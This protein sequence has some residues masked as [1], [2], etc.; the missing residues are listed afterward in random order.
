MIQYTFTQTVKILSGAEC[1]S[2]IGQLLEENGYKK[3]MLVYDK[4]LESTG[5]PNRIM[6][7]LD[8]K[9]MRYICYTEVL[10]DPPAEIVEQGAK[11]CAE[12]ACD[13]LLAV[14]GGSAIDTAK[15]INILR[16]N[17]GKILDYAA[18]PEYNVCSGLFC[19]P[20]TSGTG[21]E[22]SNGAII[23]DTEHDRKV[24][25]LC[26]RNMSE[27]AVLDPE[28]TLGLPAELTRLTGLDAFSHAAESYTST[29]AGSMSDLLCETVMRTVVEALPAVLEDGTDI[30]G[31]EKM[32]AAAA[33]GGWGLYMCGAHVGHS[34]AH[35]LGGA[36]HMVHGAACA[37]GLPGVLELISEAC[38]AKVQKIGEILGAEYTGQESTQEIGQIAAAAYSRFCEKIG[39]LKIKQYDLDEEQ[40]WDLARQIAGETF[41]VFS[42]VSITEERAY[43]LLEKALDKKQ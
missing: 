14:G 11:I 25:I 41:A 20:T 3:P 2:Q 40:M 38:P 10:P 15:G 19:V 16:F 34:L 28:L 9:D 8:E 6:K 13:C 39:L 18:N 31:R 26:F 21:S 12:Q 33:M 30:A 35:V 37:Y 24:P 23:S 36:L 32:Q 29:Q 7:S 43:G 5:I 22:L 42:P 1:I 4:G 17:G 27:W